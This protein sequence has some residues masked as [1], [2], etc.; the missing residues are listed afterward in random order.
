[1][2]TPVQRRHH[3]SAESPVPG[4]EVPVTTVHIPGTLLLFNLEIEIVF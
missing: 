4:L 2:K 1:M 3:Q